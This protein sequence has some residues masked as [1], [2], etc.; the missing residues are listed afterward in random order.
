M[1]LHCKWHTGVCVQSWC[2]KENMK[3]TNL[4]NPYIFGIFV[5]NTD[6]IIKRPE[7][8][9]QAFGETI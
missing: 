7:A 4:W 8:E 2:L 3:M 9:D 5:V 6:T 1:I